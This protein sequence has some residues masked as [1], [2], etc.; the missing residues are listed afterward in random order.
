M[1]L[2]RQQPGHSIV[3]PDTDHS[4][5]WCGPLWGPRR[6]YTLSVPARRERR[7]NHRMMPDQ[8]LGL[9]FAD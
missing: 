4:T 3:V 9:C 2:L 7:V 1:S 8:A 5:A 6:R